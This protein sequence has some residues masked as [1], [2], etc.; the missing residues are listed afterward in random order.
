MKVRIK[1]FGLLAR[2]FKDY[3]PEKG[4]DVELPEG[5][6]VR[7]LLGLL[8]VSKKEGAIITVNGIV[9]KAESELKEGN[10]IYVFHPVVGG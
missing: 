8:E 4:M 1:F 7:T 3:D 10:L 9:R 2:R 6:T 5:A